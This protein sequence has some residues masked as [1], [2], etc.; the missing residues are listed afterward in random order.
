[1]A[2][3]LHWTMHTFVVPKV[4]AWVR[5]APFVFIYDMV[6]NPTP[7]LLKSKGA[8]NIHINLLQDLI[9]YGLMNEVRSIFQ[10]Q[11]EQQ[12]SR[13]TR[14]STD[15]YSPWSCLHLWHRNT[16]T[17]SG[18]Q[19]LCS[20]LKVLC[21]PCSGQQLQSSSLGFWQHARYH[22]N[23]WFLGTGFLLKIVMFLIQ[24]TKKKWEQKRKH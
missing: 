22:G 20:I 13:Y 3:L 23:A 18:W 21:I 2:F 9:T 14:C 15:I 4:T 19:C 1:M 16:S 5:H 8:I 24:Y 12:Q 10:F 7:H 11:S 6:D 17:K